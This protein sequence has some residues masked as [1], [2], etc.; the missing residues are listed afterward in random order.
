MK[1]HSR[2]GIFCLIFFPTLLFTSSSFGEDSLLQKFLSNEAKLDD[3][4]PGYFGTFDLLRGSNANNNKAM[5]SAPITFEM[6]VANGQLLLGSG[7]MGL[8]S[9]VRQVRSSQAGGVNP[10][11]ISTIVVNEIL[12]ALISG[13]FHNRH[14]DY[15]KPPSPNLEQPLFAIF[16]R[17][18]SLD[19]QHSIVRELIENPRVFYA[20]YLKEFNLPKIANIESLTKQADSII[21]TK[22]AA[23]KNGYRILSHFF[24]AFYQNKKIPHLLD[25]TAKNIVADFASIDPS[26]V[27]FT[28]D[29]DF[30]YYNSY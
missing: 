16:V 12:W 23:V 3:L 22:D 11:E 20:F 10:S 15:I 5:L 1:T 9:D 2:M 8:R 30:T 17:N 26:S 4:I 14:S 6:A 27:N 29:P 18:V 25:E 21:A 28:S 24:N 19:T 7:Q 13:R